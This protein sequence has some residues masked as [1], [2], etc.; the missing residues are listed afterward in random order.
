MMC[1]YKW[2]KYNFDSDA[3]VW[4]ATSEDVPGLILEAG[5]REELER[6][7]KD[8]VPELMKLNSKE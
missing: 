8:A 5:T 1:D 4:I 6:K 3:G 7:V 2:V